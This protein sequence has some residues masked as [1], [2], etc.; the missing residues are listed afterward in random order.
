MIVATA[1]RSAIASRAIDTGAEPVMSWSGEIA[2]RAPSGDAVPLGAWVDAALAGRWDDIE[3]TLA[4]AP[5]PVPGT[6]L[7]PPAATAAPEARPTGEL[8]QAPSPPFVAAAAPW[9]HEA[10]LPTTFGGSRRWL[11]SDAAVSIDGE[12]VRFD[13]V[14]T[15]RLHVEGA[16]LGKAVTSKIRLTTADGR[17]VKSTIGTMSSGKRDEVLAATMYLWDVMA[18]MATPHLSSELSRRIT[19]GEIVDVAGIAISRDGVH[20]GKGTVVP[21]DRIGDPRVDGAHLVVPGDPE[22]VAVA[23]ST[24]NTFVL[25]DLIPEL[26]ALFA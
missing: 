15:F 26:R 24:V 25:P 23:I 1:V 14:A 2:L 5:A 21:W 11:V 8:P 18:A 19:A 13:Q 7:A 12:E 9:R 6:A 17:T 16:S 10:E 20:A 3:R 4:V 22:G